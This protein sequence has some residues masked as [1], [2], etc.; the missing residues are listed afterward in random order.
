MV[1]YHCD[2]FLFYCFNFFVLQFSIFSLLIINTFVREHFLQLYQFDI[3]LKSGAVRYWYTFFR[4]LCY[5]YITFLIVL[6]FFVQ[7]IERMAIKYNNVLII[8]LDCV[9]FLFFYFICALI[10]SKWMY[11]FY[12]CLSFFSLLYL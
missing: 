5:I 10:N 2:V 12:V 11:F 6:I 3:I 4:I 1:I 9:V 8:Y 7:F